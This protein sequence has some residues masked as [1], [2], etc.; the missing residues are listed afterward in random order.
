[1][2]LGL[3]TVFV[4]ERGKIGDI[5]INGVAAVICVAGE[6]RKPA[7]KEVCSGYGTG[8]TADT[9]QSLHIVIVDHIG[10]VGVGVV[11]VRC[12]TCTRPYLYRQKIYQ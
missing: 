2:Y 12:A 4:L 6:V 9:S 3:Q 10:V 8:R 7:A 5:G 1:M 11:V